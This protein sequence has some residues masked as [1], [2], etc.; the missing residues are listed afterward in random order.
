MR[1]YSKSRSQRATSQQAKP[2][3]GRDVAPRETIASIRGFPD[4]PF[5]SLREDIRD[6]QRNYRRIKL[7]LLRACVAMSGCKAKNLLGV[8]EA[9][10]EQ[11]HLRAEKEQPD[12][13]V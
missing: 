4:D 11:P 7:L 12:I 9:L 2:S 8:I 1:F 3:T 5:R 13:R 6:A 10:K